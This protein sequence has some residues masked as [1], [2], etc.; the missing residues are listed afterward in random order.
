MAFHVVTL[1]LWNEQGPHTARLDLCAKQLLALSPDVVCLQEVR[2][3]PPEV[4][5]QAATLGQQLGMQ[6]VF[7]HVAEWQ[8]GS[9]GLAILSRAPIRASV[10]VALPDPEKLGPRRAI[11]ATIQTPDGALAVVCTHLAYQLAAGRTRE[12]EVVALDEFARSQPSDG[13][14]LIC[15]DLNASPTT[16]EMRFLRG[17]TTLEGRRTFWQDA[18]LKAHPTELGHTWSSRNEYAAAQAHFDIDRRIDYVLV[19]P[20]RKD[21]RANVLGAQVVLDRPENGVYPSDHFGIHCA[22]EIRAAL[23]GPKDPT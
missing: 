5:N 14:R 11:A 3:R 16:D 22:L 1:N 20:R 21:G 19:S 18:F 15:G 9:E 4:P 17:E 2:E 7:T 8:G 10:S 13:V 6:H 12:A 23:A